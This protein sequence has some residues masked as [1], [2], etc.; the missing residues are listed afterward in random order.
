MRMQPNEK[1]KKIAV[2]HVNVR[3]SISFLVVKLI[4]ADVLTTV[5]LI[6]LYYSLYSTGLQAW[7]PVDDPLFGLSSLI[8]LSLVESALTVYVVMEWVNEYYEI[9]PHGIAHKRGVFFKKVEH[10]GIQN[11]K[12]VGISQSVLGKMLNYGTL[13]LFDW[14]LNECAELYAVHNPVRY[15]RILETLLPHVDE[16]KE[17]FGSIEEDDDE[18]L[19][20]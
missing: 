20:T 4:F 19:S 12:Q 15:V 3:M 5:L 8:L 6:I 18:E 14:R 1:T 16:N 17:T 7:L 11:I 9:S 13:T 10:H 2:D